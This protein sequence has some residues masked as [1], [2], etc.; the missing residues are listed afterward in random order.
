MS[1]IIPNSSRNTQSL[2]AIGTLIVAA[3]SIYK[4]TQKRKDDGG[5]NNSATNDETEFYKELGVSEENLPTHI[6]RE[7]HKERKRQAKVELISMKTPMYDNVCMLDTNRELMCTISMKKARWYTKKFLFLSAVF[8]T[9][10]IFS[11]LLFRD[12]DTT[13]KNP[14]QHTTHDNNI[15]QYDNVCMLDTNRELMCTISMKKARW[16]TK[17]GIAEWSTFKEDDD[18]STTNLIAEEV[19]CIRLLFEHNGADSKKTT[20][21]E[22][23]Y[24]RSAKQNVC[25]ACGDDGHHIRHYI[26]PYSYRT[27]LPEEY[28]SHMSH[29]IVILCP[30]CHLECERPTKKRMK[31]IEHDLR[32]KMGEGAIDISP[33]IDD[34]HLRHIRSCGIALVKWTE[35][36]PTEKVERYDKDVREYLASMCKKEE[37]KEAILNGK[38]KLTKSQLQKACSVNYRVK[39][40]NFVRGNEVVVRSLKGAQGIEEFII[41]WRK[42]FIA[43]VNPQHMPTGWRIDSPVLCGSMGGDVDGVKS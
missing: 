34:P 31:N 2:M 4:F 43:M 20:P 11:L 26:V 10:F 14:I 36:M 29:D 1:S 21:E 32:M 35:N 40:P 6:Q 33:F 23:L 17:K 18:G 30:D 16:Y 37:E 13:N 19:K 28:K 41:D 8:I 5:T 22:T 12:L 24:L 9:F 25:V 7:I 3:T 15:T 38:E 39:N 42:H 27:L